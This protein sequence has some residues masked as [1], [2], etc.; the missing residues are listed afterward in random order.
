MEDAKREKR[1]H[2]SQ[3]IVAKV[4]QESGRANGTSPTQGVLRALPPEM[5]RGQRH[6]T[7]TGDRQEDCPVRM[8]AIAAIRFAA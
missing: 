5:P 3:A 1:L 8:S 7:A 6:H 4:C 2:D